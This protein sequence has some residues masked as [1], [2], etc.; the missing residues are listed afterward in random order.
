MTLT[1]TLTLTLTMTLPWPGLCCT[2]TLPWPGLCC[3]MTLP[4]PGLCC[5]MTLPWPGLCC[6]MT[7]PWPGLCCT[8]TLPWPG[9]CCTMT[10][11][12]PGLCWRFR[13]GWPS[14]WRRGRG[15]RTSPAAGP[16]RCTAGR[17]GSWRWCHAP[18]SSPPAP[19][20]DGTDSQ[21]KTRVGNWLKPPGLNH[22]L[23]RLKLNE[24][25]P[26]AGIN[27]ILPGLNRLKPPAGIN[28]FKPLAGKNTI[29]AGFFPTLVK[30]GVMGDQRGQGVSRRHQGSTGWEGSTDMSTEVRR[31]QQVHRGQYLS[32]N[33][34][35]ISVKL[36]EPTHQPEELI[37]GPEENDN[38]IAHTPNASGADLR[39]GDTN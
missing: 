37:K 34:C 30:T 1:L 8:M 24:F 3:T 5:T 20:G 14:R 10:L 27:S 7:L 32:R 39:T 25:M 4:W 16:L 22:G 29:S 28:Q 23:N 12:W 38:N 18:A 9:V 35:L 13:C 31:D 26:L 36:A 6:T 21:V 19:A 15:C 17:R 33:M 11:P 2:M